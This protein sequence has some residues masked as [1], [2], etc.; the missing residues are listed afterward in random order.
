MLA[1]L[2]QWLL[3]ISAARSTTLEE[4]GNDNGNV[5]VPAMSSMFEEGMRPEKVDVLFSAGGDGA[6]TMTVTHHGDNIVCI[7]LADDL[8]DVTEIRQSDGSF[9][10]VRGTD[11]YSL[12]SSVDGIECRV[13]LLNAHQ[14]PYTLA[15]VPHPPGYLSAHI[16]L[17]NGDVLDVERD[18]ATGNYIHLC[19]HHVPHGQRR[20]LQSYHVFS[21]R[22]PQ[23]KSMKMGVVVDQAFLTNAGG[24]R[25]RAR[26]ELTDLWR[27]VSVPY[28]KQYNVRIK[29]SRLLFHD[30]PLVQGEGW[31]RCGEPNQHLDSF[32]QWRNR[33]VPTTMAGWFFAIGCNH[34]SGVQG[35]AWVGT[36][37]QGG[38][39]FSNAGSTGVGLPNS[40]LSYTRS[41]I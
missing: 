40:R 19:P 13:A 18:A 2:F 23:L 9:K 10:E 30:D 17:S 38:G 39:G 34:R 7:G 26:Q 41:D 25:E 31:A 22:L 27:K 15:D 4:A 14:R 11:G 20:R 37:G 3:L 16:V 5:N 21:C 32:T 28:E 29:V 36:M 35:V 12:R 24:N 33:K 8:S 1:L 6:L